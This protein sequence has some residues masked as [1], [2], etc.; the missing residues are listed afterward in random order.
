MDPFAALRSLRKRPRRGRR[1]AVEGGTRRDFFGD[2]LATFEELRAANAR[3]AKS[4][5][6]PPAHVRRVA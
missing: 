6:D 5:T 1:P 3:V 2:R 4:D